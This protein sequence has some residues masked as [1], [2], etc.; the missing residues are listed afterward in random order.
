MS[1]VTLIMIKSAKFVN[2]YK[3]RDL[4]VS[5]QFTTNNQ[6]NKQTN[7]QTILPGP[8]KCAEFMQNCGRKNQV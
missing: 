4:L 3:S 1:P 6:K 2:I 7:K 5:M 8:K